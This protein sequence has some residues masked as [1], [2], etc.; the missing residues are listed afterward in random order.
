VLPLRD[1]VP[2]RSFPVVTVG[3]IDANVIVWPPNV[4]AS[5]AI[6]G[7]LVGYMLLRP[8]AKVLTAVILIFLFG[9]ATIRFVVV[10]RPLRPAY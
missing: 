9:L 4:G 5:G 7:V 3:L 10:R 6:A 8:R 2:T 1:N